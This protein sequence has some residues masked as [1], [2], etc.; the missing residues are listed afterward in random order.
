MLNHKFQYVTQDVNQYTVA[1]E[2]FTGLDALLNS[3][4]S[5]LGCTTYF[6][7]LE[8]N[9]EYEIELK[10]SNISDPSLWDDIMETAR[11]I[12]EELIY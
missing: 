8:G 6:H 3:K 4:Y 5:G 1:L 12:L 11:F 9:N 10:V 2:V 7:S